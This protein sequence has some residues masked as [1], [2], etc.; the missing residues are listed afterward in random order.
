V[1]GSRVV[2]TGVGAVT[3]LGIG[4]ET[5]WQGLTAG[6]SGIRRIQAWDASGLEVQ[7]AGEVPEFDPKN[8][9]DFKIARRMDRFA[10]FAVA[11][12]REALEQS[13]LQITDDNRDMIGVVVN[14][15]GGGIPTIE[16]EVGVMH[17]K[18]PKRVSPFL[19]P[20]FAPNMA[21]CQVSI[22]FGIRG[23]LS[24]SA[25]ACASGIQAFI[26]AVHMIQRGEVDAIVTGGTEAGITPVAVAGLANMG[27]LSR[28]NDD[29]PAASRPFDL[30]RDGFV[31][32][33]GAAI[34]ILESEEHAINRGAT[35]LCEVSGG[36]YTS[37]AYHI[38]APDPTGSGAALAIKRALKWADLDPTAVDYVAAHATAT[39]I[40]DVAETDAIKNALGDHAY[41]IALS[42]NKSMLG[43]LLGAA[44]S[45]SGLAC[46]LAIRDG[47][48]PPTINLT[49]PDPKCDLDYVPNI[50][51]KMTVNVALAN[52]FG[53]GGQNACAVFK[54]YQD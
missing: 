38:T 2:V 41:K 15:G 21:S 44:G 20:L 32:S 35:I 39:S 6:C 1:K 9:M 37:D 49:D 33:E 26:D 19:I 10:Q 25:A 23:P 17:T 11:A 28:R 54:R 34:F 12:S 52:G 30:G 16:N 43:H 53:F 42:A 36:A 7:I 22:A 31:F 47:I 5:F 50:A 4:A 51:R 45:V 27:A 48:V 8:F 18:G 14:T 40:G 24:T 46:I 13:G 3:P 29:P